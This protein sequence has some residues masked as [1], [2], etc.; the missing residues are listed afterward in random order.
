MRTALVTG[1]RGFVGRHM[2][3]ALEDLGYSVSGLDLLD[4]FHHDC[5]DYFRRVDVRFD[6]VVHCAAVV[7]GRTMI[8]GE[9]LRLAAED[10][11]IDAELFRWALRTRPGRIVYFSSSAAY[12]VELQEMGVH[13][14][15]HESDIGGMHFGMPDATYGWVKLT[16]ERLAA[17][18]NAEGIRT[19]VFRPFSGYGADQA[20]DYPFPAIVQRAIE[21]EER[22]RGWQNDLEAFR[23]WGHT[24]STRDWVHID[25]VVGCVLAAIE[26][27]D[28][29]PMNI[30]TGRSTSFAE[31]AVMALD[32]VGA[33][34]PAIVGDLTMPRGVMHRVGDPTEMR[35]VYT[36]RITVEEG[37]ARAVKELRLWAR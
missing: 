22:N 15:L 3:A 9:P 6:L 37:I 7:G 33:W 1:H 19:H 5:R 31:L 20:L 32:A 28:I 34:A 14:L 27:D 24:D 25:D 35:Q 18:A 11:S 29:G 13:H 10:L 26:A 2:V 4:E 21:H 36:A 17:E 23:V 30:C 8:D 16:G 12:P